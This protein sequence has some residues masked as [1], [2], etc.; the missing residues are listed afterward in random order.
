[1]LFASTRARLSAVPP[2]DKGTTSVI[3]CAGNPAAAP[4]ALNPIRQ[5]NITRQAD[6]RSTKNAS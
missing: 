5:P 4:A 6:K 1:M 3:G 2:A